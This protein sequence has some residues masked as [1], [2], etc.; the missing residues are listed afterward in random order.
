MQQHVHVLRS[1]LANV[2]RLSP[3][4]Y[5]TCYVLSSAGRADAPK[6][7]P[8]SKA[9]SFCSSPAFKKLTCG[10]ASDSEEEAAADSCIYCGTV[11]G[12]MPTKDKLPQELSSGSDFTLYSNTLS[13]ACKGRVVVRAVFKY[14]DLAGNCADQGGSRLITPGS[15]ADSAGVKVVTGVVRCEL[16]VPAGAGASSALS[17]PEGKCWRCSK[18]MCPSKVGVWYSEVYTMSVQGC[19]QKFDPT[20]G[21][22]PLK[23]GLL[24]QPDQKVLVAKYEACSDAGC[25]DQAYEDKK[26]KNAPAPATREC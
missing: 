15:D 13:L 18:G 25:F 19:D 4:R 24:V 12:I 1:M 3:L 7:A 21:Y 26:Y 11:N 14:V 9:R 5:N 8:G 2:Q 6:A 20:S 10:L 23:V 22:D 16:Q 17:A